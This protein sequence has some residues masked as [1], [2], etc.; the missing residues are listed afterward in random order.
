MALEYKNNP[1]DDFFSEVMDLLKDSPMND[2]N[3]ENK[4]DDG[5]IAF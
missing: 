5:D 4:N 2:L 1:P 3:N